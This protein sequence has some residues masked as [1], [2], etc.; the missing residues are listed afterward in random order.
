MVAPHVSDA[1][2]YTTKL[3]VESGLEDDVSLS[4]LDSPRRGQLL[5]D[6]RGELGRAEAGCDAPLES[7]VAQSLAESSIN[8]SAVD[9]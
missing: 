8:S 7:L 4:N 1:D 3:D 5:L 2:G 9:A 6:V